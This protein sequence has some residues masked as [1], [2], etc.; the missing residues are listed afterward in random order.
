MTLALAMQRMVFSSNAGA[1][2]LFSRDPDAVAQVGFQ[3][4][5]VLTAPWSQELF[6]LQ[7][8]CSIST[9][10]DASSS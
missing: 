2:K 1:E 3:I 4:L 5:Q 6:K 8:L 9:S 10:Y 7:S